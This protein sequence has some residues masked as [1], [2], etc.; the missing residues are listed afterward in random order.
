MFLSV[1]IL[2]TKITAAQK[3]AA[4]S[5]NKVRGLYF[6]AV[7]FALT[8]ELDISMNFILRSKMYSVFHEASALFYRQIFVRVRFNKI[9]QAIDR[10]IIITMC[11]PS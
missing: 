8:I 3:E 5:Y 7:I 4:L 6:L 9:W 2:L 11:A 10:A 1:T